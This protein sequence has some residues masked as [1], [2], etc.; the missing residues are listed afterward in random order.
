MF[1]PFETLSQCGCQM[2]SYLEYPLLCLSISN[3]SKVFD[4]LSRLFWTRHAARVGYLFLWGEEGHFLLKPISG[5]CAA[6]RYGFWPKCFEN[7]YSGFQKGLTIAHNSHL[8]SIYRTASKFAFLSLVFLFIAF[9][10]KYS[11]RNYWV[12]FGVPFILM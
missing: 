8:K 3:F 4:S 9:M 1:R 6:K 12:R 2:F 7:N 10:E 11:S 5:M